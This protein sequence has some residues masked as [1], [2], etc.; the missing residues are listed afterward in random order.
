[1]KILT[2]NGPVE[3]KSNSNLFTDEM[4]TQLKMIKKNQRIMFENIKAVGP[5]GA[6]VKLSP[7]TVKVN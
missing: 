7:L 6:E 3:F 2:P 4:K 5:D 1:M